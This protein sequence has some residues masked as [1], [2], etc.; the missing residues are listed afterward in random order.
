M[1]KHDLEHLIK[2]IYNYTWNFDTKKP[3]RKIKYINN[4]G[5]ATVK[6]TLVKF[7][8]AVDKAVILTAGDD[9]ECIG[10]FAEDDIA[11]GLETFIIVDGSSLFLLK[12][13][14]AATRGNWIKTSDVAGRADAS[15]AA[16]PLGGVAQLDEHMQ[17]IGHCCE[18]IGAGTDILVEGLLSFN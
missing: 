5:S 8:T 6:G 4:T 3:C 7:D 12:D 9:H 10:T 2:Q 17:E 1:D 13:A 15:L 16:P 18:S 14:T 11:D